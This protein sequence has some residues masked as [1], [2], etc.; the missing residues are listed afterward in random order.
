MLANGDPAVASLFVRS[1]RRWA[2]VGMPSARPELDRSV[3]RREASTLSGGT[4]T[5]YRPRSV[6]LQNIN[7]G[8]VLCLGVT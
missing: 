4:K 7:R 5:L 6:R 1:A 3:L 2:S 8:G